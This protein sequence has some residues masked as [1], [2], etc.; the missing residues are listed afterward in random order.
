[1]PKKGKMNFKINVR[2]IDNGF[3]VSV[4]NR[5]DVKTSETFC[6]DSNAIIGQI[7]TWIDTIFKP[8]KEE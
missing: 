3:L 7:R 6:N 8:Q 1:M 4:E 2:E 5:Y